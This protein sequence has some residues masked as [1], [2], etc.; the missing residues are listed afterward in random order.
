VAYLLPCRPSR[1]RW[2]SP[3]CSTGVQRG[4]DP[5]YLAD[6]FGRAYLGAI[7]GFA[8]PFQMTFNALGPLAAAFLYD[9]TQSYTLILFVFVAMYG[10]ATVA[11][12][13]SRPIQQ[14]SGPR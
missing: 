12:L 11:I 9:M 6:Y 1:R 2:F 10:L 4:A 5:E 14:R 8:T 7:R 3:C 13:A